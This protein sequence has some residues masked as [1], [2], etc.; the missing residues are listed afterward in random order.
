[1]NVQLACCPF[2]VQLYHVR[3]LHVDVVSRNLDEK[4]YQRPSKKTGNMSVA[5]SRFG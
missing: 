2:D 4:R 3:G 5:F 1:M